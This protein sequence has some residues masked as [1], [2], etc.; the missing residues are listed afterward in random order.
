MLY[1][2][3]IK[4]PTKKRMEGNYYTLSIPPTVLD[5]MTYTK[6][7]QQPQQRDLAMRFA[8]NYEY[9]QSLLRPINVTNRIFSIDPGGNRWIIDNGRNLRVPTAVY[10]PFSVPCRA[11]PFVLRLWQRLMVVS[12]RSGDQKCPVGGLRCRPAGTGCH[13]IMGGS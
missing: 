6:S 1:N 10:F 2:P 11:W 7:F 12:F 3:Q 9:A 5:L 13:G 8:A 4:N